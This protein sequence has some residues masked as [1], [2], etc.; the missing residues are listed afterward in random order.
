MQI[1]KVARGKKGM[2]DIQMDDGS[3][4]KAHEESVVKYRL[5]P[6]RILG[7]EEYN[8][9][10]SAIQF[11]AAY[12]RA[13]G[14]ISY[15]LRTI[16][17]MRKYLAEDYAPVMIDETIKRLEEEGYLNDAHY[18]EAL[19]NTMLATTDKGPHALERELKKHKVHPDIIRENVEKF[20]AQIDPERMNKLKDKQLKRHK[21]SYQQFKMK[22]TEK[23]YQKGYTGGHLAMID[24]DDDYDEDVHFNRD[25]EKYL[26]RYQKKETG[27]ALKQ[28]LIQAMMRKGYTYDSIQEKLGGLDDETFEHNDET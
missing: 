17:E 19:K 22:L 7:E 25:F 12:V 20:S 8:E 14:Y 26:R 3:S 4:F 6:E 18:A 10:L 24:F 9:V 15:K 23:L 16:H 13:L 28:K 2:Y 21:G 11:D 5:I 1:K 27:Y